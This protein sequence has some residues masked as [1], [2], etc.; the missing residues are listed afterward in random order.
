MADKAREWTDKELARMEKKIDKTYKQASKELTK[1]WDEYMKRGESRISA[2]RSAYAEAKQ[3]GDKE[4][5]IDARNRLSDALQNFTLRND[6]Y[7]AMVESVTLDM[8]QVNQQALSYINGQLPNVY[9]EN[10]DQVKVDLN[11]VKIDYTLA[12]KGTVK[13]MIKDGDIKLPKKKISVPKDVAWNTKKINSSVLQG[14]LQGEPLNKIADRLMPIMD[15]NR[16]SAIR[17]ARTLVTGAEN[18]GRIDSYHELADQGIIIKK[19]WIA[20]GDDRTRDAHLVMDGQEVDIDEPFMDGD[21]NPLDYPADPSGEPATVY[22][23]RCS[24][25]THI[26]GVQN[27]DGTIDYIDYEHEEVLHQEQIEE[28]I[29]RRNQDESEEPLELIRPQEPQEIQESQEVVEEPDAIKLSE[30]FF[31]K[32]QSNA[33]EDFLDTVQGKDADV[34]K[35]YGTLGDMMKQQSCQMKISY[36]AK[37]H[38]VVTYSN[39]IT[40]QISRLDVKIPKMDGDPLSQSATTIHELGHFLD[41]LY[42]GDNYV[43]ATNDE[44]KNA[45]IGGNP[46]SD[47]VKSLFAQLKEN[48][49]KAYNEIMDSVKQSNSE[50]N[51]K[52]SDA[53]KNSDWSTV[54]ELQ[55]E[56][57]KAWRQGTDNALSAMRTAH[58]GYTGLEDIYDAISGGALQR[59]GYFG[60]GSRYYASSENKSAETF[61]NYCAMSQTNPQALQILKDEQ[62]EIYNACRNMVKGMLGE[63]K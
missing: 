63:E 17:N 43:S 36:T 52:I 11:N 16:T 61:A 12:D 41:I 15:N 62:P 29:E 1:K 8:A 58:E 5:I 18:R 31:K 48:G 49:E 45:I 35:L 33:L 23:C 20:T 40:H 55:K 4:S 51:D 27:E 50:Y 47:N 24:M 9:A 46:M 59:D 26:V 10:H 57:D 7:K 13:R 53:F 14:I 60:H 44:L 2:L 25:R 34:A 21:N 30:D 22:N 32:K 28:E 3:S 37:G 19:V 39:R 38:E 54:K 56:R 42:G 6:Q